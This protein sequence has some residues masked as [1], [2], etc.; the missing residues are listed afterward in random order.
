M[1]IKNSFF[2]KNLLY[3]IYVYHIIKFFYKI[4]HINILVKYYE[5]LIFIL[6]PSSY[7]MITTWVYTLL[8]A[9]LLELDNTFREKENF[10]VKYNENDNMMYTHQAIETQC[11]SLCPSS[12]KMCISICAQNL[13]KLNK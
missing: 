10:I 5:K 13:K 9:I 4:K 12:S 1:L 8:S 3:I 7:I 6:I 2:F 11:K